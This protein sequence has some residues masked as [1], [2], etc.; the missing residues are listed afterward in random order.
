MIAAFAA[1]GMAD[2]QSDPY[3][4]LEEIEGPNALAWVR[5][6]NEVSRDELEAHPLFEPI[7]ERALEILTS[8]DRIAS[9]R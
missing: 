8:G 2:A 5:G 3:L 1:T 6:Q 4:W 9:R 7:H